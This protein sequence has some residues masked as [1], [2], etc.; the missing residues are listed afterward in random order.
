VDWSVWREKGRNGQLTISW[1]RKSSM[2]DALVPSEV[3]LKICKGGK[4][5]VSEGR[6]E[7]KRAGRTLE[8]LL[9]TLRMFAAMML[10]MRTRPISRDHVATSRSMSRVTA[11]RVRREVRRSVPCDATGVASVASS[12]RGRG[13]W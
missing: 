8:T 12:G 2:K 5:R 13:L 9:K 7:G 1:A 10:P 11:I 6:R 3:A 4:E